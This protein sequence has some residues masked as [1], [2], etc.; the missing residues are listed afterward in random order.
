MPLGTV[1]LGS[2]N[3]CQCHKII[4]R[5]VAPHSI[6][7]FH[8]C[9]HHK[10]DNVWPVLS[11]FLDLMEFVRFPEEG[12]PSLSD[13]DRVRCKDIVTTRKQV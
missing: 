13:A 4:R 8:T 12:G 7:L 1:L 6:V 5:D 11:P 3:V 10:G 9:H 2:L